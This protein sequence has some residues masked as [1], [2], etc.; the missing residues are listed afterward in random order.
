MAITIFH[1]Y[2]DLLPTGNLCTDIVQGLK[3]AGYY[4]KPEQ[5]SLMIKMQLVQPLTC[6]Y[7]GTKM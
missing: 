5:K 3:I 2:M 7:S 4:G 1:T 6:G